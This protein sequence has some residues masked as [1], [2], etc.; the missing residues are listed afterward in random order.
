MRAR[1]SRAPARCRSAPA[2]ASRSSPRKDDGGKPL[3]GRCDVVISGNTP[4]ARFWTLTL[5]DA[6]GRLVANALN[7][8]GFTSQEIV[9]KTDG[10]FEITRR[11]ARALRQLAADRRR[12]ALRSGAAPLRHAGRRR[13][14]HRAEAPMPAIMTGTA[15]DPLAALD[16]RRRAA[17]RDRASCRPCCRCRARQRRTPMRGSHAIYAGQRRGAAARPAPAKRAAA[18]HGSGF[19]GRGLPLRPVAPAAQI[20]ARRSARPIR[21][22]RSIRATVWPITPSM[23]APPAAA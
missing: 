16:P 4:A 17:R 5:Y 8:H 13:D 9:R 23:T 21:R 7:R 10:N 3:D 19:C 11:A 14:A 20:F 1:R 6:D 22:C 18:V 2:T 12:R 15:H